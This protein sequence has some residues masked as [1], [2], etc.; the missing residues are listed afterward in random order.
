MD[1]KEKMCSNCEQEIATHCN[2]ELCEY[3]WQD[4]E[5]TNE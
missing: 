3:C 5:G 4:A 2:L 1:N